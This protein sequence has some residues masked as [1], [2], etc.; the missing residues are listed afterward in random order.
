MYEGM[1]ALFQQSALQPVAA[2]ASQR[3]DMEHVASLR[4]Q[5]GKRHQRIAYL[6]LI[7]AGNPYTPGIVLVEMPELHIQHG[8]LQLVESGVETLVAEHVFFSEP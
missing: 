5:T 6:F 2:P 7:D 8:G 1:Y 4:T 3:V